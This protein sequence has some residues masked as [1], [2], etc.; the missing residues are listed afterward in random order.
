MSFD[1]ISAFISIELQTLCFYILIGVSKTNKTL[2]ASL[3]YYILG[4]FSTAI[5]ILGIALIYF[6]TGMI[7]F[8]D[9]ADFFILE[10]NTEMHFVTMLGCILITIAFFFKLSLAPFHF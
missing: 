10:Y 5:F 4:S 7:N 8:K 2:E 6:S 3:K 9:L 1:F